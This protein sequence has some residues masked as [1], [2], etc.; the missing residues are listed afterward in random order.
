TELTDE[1]GCG[2]QERGREF[3]S[4]T[5]RPRRCGWLDG[6]VLRYATRVNGLTSLAVTKLDVLDGCKQIKVCTGYRHGGTVHR[7]MPSDLQTLS[8]CEPIYETAKGWATPTTGAT[9]Y[10]QLPAEAKRYLDRIAELAA[11]PIDIISTGSKRQDTIVLR[12]PMSSKR[13][14]AS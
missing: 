13:R 6:V 1:I 5:G 10:K 8:E 11:C 14:R 7:D 2:L 12:N 3:G 4:T 9:S